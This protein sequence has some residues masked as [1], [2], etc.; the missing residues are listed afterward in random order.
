M[1]PNGFHASNERQVNVSRTHPLF[2][3]TRHV[4]VVWQCLIAGLLLFATHAFAEAPVVAGKFLRSDGVV[5]TAIELEAGSVMRTGVMCWFDMSDGT[6][7]QP[8][9]PN[10]SL[11]CVVRIKDSAAEIYWYRSDALPVAN[12]VERF[13]GYSFV[14]ITTPG[15]RWLSPLIHTSDHLLSYLVTI[16]LFVWP[17]MIG[18]KILR[19]TPKI[20]W[21]R[22]LRVFW[23]VVGVFLTLFYSV[24][25]TM[26]SAISPPI[27]LAL[28]TFTVAMYWQ[29]KKSIQSK[30]SRLPTS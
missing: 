21:R 5:V 18:R 23:I 24:F 19:A 4:T 29:I 22:F 16:A 28:L 1:Q 26:Y 9:R 12:R 25:I 27:F 17:L 30:W 14:D 15:R 8:P 20:G 10:K 11:S 7:I 3:L 6:H 13:D 2:T